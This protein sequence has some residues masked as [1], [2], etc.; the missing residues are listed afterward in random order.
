MKNSNFKS[1]FFFIGLVF[2]ICACQQNDE[3]EIDSNNLLLGNWVKPVYK[4]DTIIFNRAKVLDKNKYGISFA[5]NGVFTERTSGW[6]GT[7]PLSF[8]DNKGSWTL[9]EKLIKV[10]VTDFP[11][12]F[13]WSLISLSET[14]LVVKRALTEQEREHQ[15]LL[16]LFNEIETLANSIS[17]T[18]KNDWTYTAYGSKACGGPKGYIAYSKKINTVDFL[19]KINN[20]TKAEKLYNTKW[21][22]VSD[23]SLAPQPK[24]IVCENGTPLLKY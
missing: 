4:N 7:P 8:F 17:C 10:D 12:D 9:Q 1:L 2:S 20:Y 21:G 15:H 22:I 11:G 5:K 16:N 23:C 14:T 13:N 3:L 6:C 18:D 19:T 24:T